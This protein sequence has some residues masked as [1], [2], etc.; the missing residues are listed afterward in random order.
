MITARKPVRFLAALLV[1][2]FVCQT[3]DAQQQRQRRPGAILYQLDAFATDAEKI[4]AEDVLADLVPVAPIQPAGLA[5][6]QPVFRMATLPDAN[7]ATGRFQDE[8]TVAATLEATGGVIFAEPD[9]AFSPVATTPNDPSYG[10]QWHHTTMQ[11]PAAWDLITGDGSVIVGIIDTGVQSDHPDLAAHMLLPGKNTVD[12]TT[13]TEPIHFH[14]THVAGCTAAIG[15]NGVGV[16]GVCWN[17]QIL[18]IK[19]SNRSDGVAYISDMAEG[20]IW[21]TDQGAKVLNLSYGGF[22]SSTINS[23][24]QY[25]RDNGALLFMAA[26]NDSLNLDADPDWTSFILVG[27]TTSADARSSFSNYG[28]PIDI[29]APGSSIYA[30]NIN[31]GYTYASGTSMATP[32]AAGVA[33]LMWTANPTLTPAELETLLY[34][35]CDDIGAAGEDNVH[36]HGRVNTYA[37]VQ[38]ALNGAPPIATGAVHVATDSQVYSDQLVATDPDGAALT[39]SIVSNGS[40][41]TAVITNSST[42][43]FTYTPAANSIGDV[44]SFSFK[45]NNGSQDSN[46]ATVTVAIVGPD[47]IIPEPNTTLLTSSVTFYWKKIAGATEY[48][49]SAGSTAGGVDYAASNVGANLYKT[50]ANLP[51]DGSTIY[52]RLGAR[53]AGSWQYFDYTYTA[54]DVAASMTDPAPGATFN[55]SSVTF[56]WSAGTGASEYWLR[57]GSAYNATDYFE[58]STGTNRSQTVTGLPLDGSTVYVTLYTKIG[59]A[60]PRKDYTYTAV[61]DPNDGLAAISSHA[62]GATLAGADVTFSWSAGVDITE[63]W[64]R[65]GSTSGGKDLYDASTG[66]NASIALTGLPTDGRNLY[67][68]LYSKRNSAWPYLTYTFKASSSGGGSSTPATLTTPADGATLS[69]ATQTFQWSAG[70]GV[71]E[72]WLRLGSTQGGYD[73]YDASAGTNLSQ[74]VSGIP[75][76]GRTIFVTLYSKIG[77]TWPYNRY[78]L[79]ASSG[80]GGGGSTG[81]AEMTTPSPDATLSGSTATFE[82]SAGTGVSEYWLRLGSTRGGKDIYDATAGA[83]LSKSVSSLPTDGRTIHVTLYSKVGASWPF[84]QYTVTA[85][86]GGGGSSTA[87]LTS[88]APS[89]TLSGANVTFQ[90]SA[91]SG[92]S[93]YWLRLGSTQGAS[94]IY[95]ATAGT[96]LSQAVTGIPTDGRTVYVTLYT[97]TGTTWPYNQYTLT[98][99]SGGGSGSETAELT[100]PAADSTLTG[101]TVTFQWSAGTGASEYWLRLGSTRG[102]GDIYDATAGTNLSQSVSGIPTDGRAIHVTLYSKVG[103]TWPYNQYTLTAS[104]GGGGGGST[105]AEL[106]SPAPDSTLAG[107]SVTFQWSAGSSASEYWLR[108]GSTRGGKDIYDASAGT[109]LSKAVSGLPTDGRTIHVTLYSKS[110]STWPFNQYTLTANSGGG[111]VLA[112]LTSPAAGSTLSGSTVTFQWTAGT[113]VSE[114][115]LRLGSTRGGKDIHDAT[116]GT[117]LSKSV[118]G[119]PTDGRTI[120]VTMYSKVGSTWPFLQYTLTAAGMPSAAGIAPELI[121]PASGSTLAGSTATFEWTVVDGASEYWLTIETETGA[122]DIYDAGNGTGVVR[123]VTDLPTDGGP[124]YVTVHARIETGWTSTTYLLTAAA[125]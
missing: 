4:A 63:Y 28:I 62:N 33:A 96:N 82:W 50:V 73:I 98:A 68:I 36:G 78:T 57:V 104:S 6:R 46:T 25:A 125:P 2:G 76:D 79:T 66:S 52:V 29:S 69:A 48:N 124:L 99:A 88:P 20:I 87:A 8:E 119:I 37:A 10:S 44:D 56:S 89:S 7:G 58:A 16:S 49:L 108:L 83:N 120:H 100:S 92:A 41:G 27:A 118:S 95:D 90:W 22:Q 54:L 61:N 26:G 65:L 47:G 32:V 70:T 123:T 42:G 64:F 77:S 53:V 12:D 121:R 30:T 111:A 86:T 112:Q 34:D 71:S 59:S 40:S 60:W 15:N 91:G 101:S 116:A 31:S 105:I 115:W 80:G 106:T 51:T 35:S 97:K 18:P 3:A 43:A 75:T 67:A 109:N 110:G 55:S 24:A 74:S 113:G 114:Y 94:D 72:Y 23:A 45:V 9:Y 81:I 103:S 84:N 102:A 122:Q 5:D 17:A 14:G 21:A 38:A 93:E 117:N 85:S 107:S 39:Y 1:I 19:I 13:N 11:S